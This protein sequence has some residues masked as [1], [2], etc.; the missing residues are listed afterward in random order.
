M[1]ERFPKPWARND[2]AT[3]RP[4]DDAIPPR[5]TSA[6]LAD[7]ACCC[8][9]RAMVQAV[10]PPTPTRPHRTE[11]LLCGHHFRISRQALSAL[12]A[13]VRELPWI[14]DSTAAWIRLE[15]HGSLAQISSRGAVA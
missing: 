9:A 15:R 1:N 10:M 6:D 4:L 3:M 13:A 14:P 5:E 7:R 2:S 11:L 8:S 12:G